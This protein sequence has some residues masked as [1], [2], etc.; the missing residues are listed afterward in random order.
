MTEYIKKI[1]RTEPPEVIAYNAAIDRARKT[2]NP[3]TKTELRGLGVYT[4]V[5]H[6]RGQS[7]NVAEYQSLRGTYM[8]Q[9]SR[10]PENGNILIGASGIG[11]IPG[12]SGRADS[13][14][15]LLEM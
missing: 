7:Y 5:R 12:G 2:K 14:Y 6:L 4:E 9:V 3:I 15:F 10:K 8:I 11:C 13:R 1:D